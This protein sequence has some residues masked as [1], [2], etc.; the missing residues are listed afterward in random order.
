MMN[1]WFSLFLIIQSDQEERLLFWEAIVSIILI[2]NEYVSYCSFRNRTI[3]IYRCK[4][5]DKKR[6]TFFFILV[7]MT[8][9]LTLYNKFSKIPPS[10]LM[11]FSTFVRTWLV[12]HWVHRNDPLCEQEHPLWHVSESRVSTLPLHTSLFSQSHTRKSNGVRSED[13]SGQLM[14]LLQSIH[15]SN[16]NSSISETEIG[17]FYSY[18]HFYLKSIDTLLLKILTVPPTW[19]ILYK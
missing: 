8:H 12:W 11:H 1:K 18:E 10:T 6:G 5:I 13:F 7:Q 3:W 19:N 9:L 2:K 16:A 4:I 17:N 14:A 15:R